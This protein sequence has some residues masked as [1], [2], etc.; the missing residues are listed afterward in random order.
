MERQYVGARYVPYF[1]DGPNGNEWQNGVGYE[2]L[3]VVTYLNTS[4]TS[5]IPVPASVGNP[6]DNPKYW[7]ATGNY[8]AQVEQ[9]R[10]EVENLE[11]NLSTLQTNLINSITFYTPEQFGAK[12][13]GVTDD[14]AAIQAALNKNSVVLFTKKTYASS[15]SLNIG[16]STILGNDCVI[17]FAN[18]NEQNGLYSS[19]NNISV[20][21]I[22]VTNVN[23]G[24]GFYF[25]YPANEGYINNIE[26]TSCANGLYIENSWYCNFSNIKLKVTTGVGCLI[27]QMNGTSI[28]NLFIQGGSTGIQLESTNNSVSFTGLTLENCQNYGLYF[29]GLGNI[30]INSVYFENCCLN[31]S[32]QYRLIYGNPTNFSTI[33]IS[34]I[35]VLIRGNYPD[36]TISSFSPQVR[37]L[38]QIYNPSNVSIGGFN[39]YVPFGNQPILRTPD[40]NSRNKV[41]IYIGRITN[42]TPQFELNNVSSGIITIA[43]MNFQ[44]YYLRLA[45]TMGVSGSGAAT[46]NTK[47]LS[48]F[49][50]YNDTLTSPTV[51]VN[52]TNKTFTV[53]LP[54]AFNS[55]DCFYDL[56]STFDTASVT[57]V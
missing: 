27:N 18:S 32:N 55:G 13:D 38:S 6:A 12:G 41:G 14:S 42:N 48:F 30:T 25:L 15:H 24:Y 40:N 17:N 33:I 56:F 9:Y 44:Q 11:N 39:D 1:Y 21:D 36:K 20:Q 37:L 2:A 53:Q 26:A 29:S 35:N 8:N 31:S 34:V 28:N 4:Y 16:T 43:S 52:N 46:I 47:V 49:D 10:Q 54:A 7:V 22:S 23:N 19:N 45:F 57:L 50:V 3:T 51:T 5:K